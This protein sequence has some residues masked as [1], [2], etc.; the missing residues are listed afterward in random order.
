MLRNSF[1]HTLR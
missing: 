1:V